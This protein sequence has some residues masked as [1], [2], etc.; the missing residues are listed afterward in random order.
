M[1]EVAPAE[2]GAY[3]RRV[4]PSRPN[5]FVALPVRAGAWFAGLPAPPS[6]IRLFAPADLHITVAFFGAVDPHAARR[7]F[8]IAASLCPPSTHARLGPVRAFGSK[9]NP[10]A[11]SAVVE[12]MAEEKVEETAEPAAPRL[13]PAMGAEDDGRGSVSAVITR[14]RDPLLEAAGARPDRRPPRPHVTLARISRRAG[15][16]QRRAALDWAASLDLRAPVLS[17]DRLALYT[18][19]RDRHR[20]LFQIVEELDLG[21]PMHESGA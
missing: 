20:S 21:A 13:Q 5:W 17:L 7:A 18:W 16:A 9:R 12:E 2:G 19:A 1:R 6:T 14:L 15:P 8:A 3:P 11:L 10:S 4:S